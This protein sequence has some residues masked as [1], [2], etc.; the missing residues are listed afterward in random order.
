[1]EPYK[2]SRRPNWL[3]ELHAAVPSSNCF[4]PI[5]STV[6]YE[7]WNVH[8]TD[9]SASLTEWP[10]DALWTEG[11]T[12]SVTPHEIAIIAILLFVYFIK[13]VISY[14]LAFQP[15][16]FLCFNSEFYLA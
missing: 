5:Q 1:M 3:N 11:E 15:P 2:R 10:R 6:I 13:T 8:E 12:L 7:I 16:I 4:Q 14:S 9:R